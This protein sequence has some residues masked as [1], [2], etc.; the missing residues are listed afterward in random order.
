MP[1][2]FL[3]PQRDEPLL[4]LVDMRE[5]LPEDDLVF[6]VVDAVATLDLGGFRRLYDP[7]GLFA[8][9]PAGCSGPGCADGHDLLLRSFLS[10]VLAAGWVCHVHAACAVAGA[11][12]ADHGGDHGDV[13]FPEDRAAAGG[14]D[15][16]PAGPVAGR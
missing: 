1:Q 3:C 5:W 6:V 4:L 11:R 2:N 7:G 9:R 16:G 14:G 8:T 15:P 13:W 12:S 10:V